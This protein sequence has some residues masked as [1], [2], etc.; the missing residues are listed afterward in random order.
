[1]FV[2]ARK[3]SSRWLL[4]DPWGHEFLLPCRPNYAGRK[5][6]IGTL[7]TKFEPNGLKDEKRKALTRTTIMAHMLRDLPSSTLFASQ[8]HKCGCLDNENNGLARG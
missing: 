7:E 3:D 2:N 4:A 1:M 6:R 8:M 5:I